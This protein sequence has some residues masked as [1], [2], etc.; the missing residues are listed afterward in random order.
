MTVMK[1][2]EGNGK[3]HGTQGIRGSY[4][5]NPKPLR[6]RLE[7]RSSDIGLRRL[8]ARGQG[9][10]SLGE[11]PYVWKPAKPSEICR[12]HFPATPVCRQT[13]C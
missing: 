3:E 10:K 8:K 1:E 13:Q 4:T 6:V 12:L 2:H 11:D 9:S 7:G 5:L